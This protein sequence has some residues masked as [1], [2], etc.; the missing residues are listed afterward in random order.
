M[1]LPGKC[2]LALGLGRRPGRDRR[3]PTLLV[4]WMCVD[5]CESEATD[6]VP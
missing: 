6:D 3:A 5:A 2:D 4:F 1:E